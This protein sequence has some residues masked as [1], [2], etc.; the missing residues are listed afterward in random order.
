MLSHNL[1]TLTVLLSIALGQNCPAQG[2][3][4]WAGEENEP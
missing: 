4:T 1:A 2:P 3:R